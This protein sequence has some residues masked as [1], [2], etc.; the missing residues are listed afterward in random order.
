LKYNLASY[1]LATD[2]G[3]RTTDSQLSVFA[4]LG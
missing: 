1:C 4:Q 3:Q 2:D